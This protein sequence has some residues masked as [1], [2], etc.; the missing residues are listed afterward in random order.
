MAHATG[1]SKSVGVNFNDWQ[2]TSN[3]ERYSGGDVTQFLSSPASWKHDFVQ[4]SI[5]PVAQPP[6]PTVQAVKGQTIWYQTHVYFPVGYDYLSDNGGINGGGRLKFMRHANY[7][8][9]GTLRNYSDIYINWNNAPQSWEYT[10]EG[11]AGFVRFGTSTNADF[12]TLGAWTEVQFA[13][14]LDTAPQDSGGQAMVRMWVDD[15]FL[16][17]ITSKPTITD[18][19]DYYAFQLFMP[20]WNGDAPATQTMWLDDVVLTTT[21]PQTTD[22]GGR[23]KIARK[24]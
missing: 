24:N 12:P 4:G 21:P 11:A 16:G 6:L 19:N 2:G 20:T 17:E 15:K 14:T 23:P 10:Y 7:R 9:D 22:A 8:G 13:V 5:G 1:G 3:S 18:D